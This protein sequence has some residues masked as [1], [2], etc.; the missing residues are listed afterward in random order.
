[1]WRDSKDSLVACDDGKVEK[2]GWRSSKTVIACIL[3]GIEAG[4]PKRAALAPATVDGLD[5]TSVVSGL[6][7]SLGAAGSP[8]LL[9]SLTTAGFNVV[10]PLGVARLVDSP[11]IVVYTYKPSLDRLVSALQ[12]AQLPFS[13]ARIRLLS[14]VERVFEA[15]T[16]KGRLYLL[17]WGLDREE[18]VE[19]VESA[20]IHARK[21]EPLRIA[22]YT[23]SEASEA[24][25]AA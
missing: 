9:D 7:L 1:M 14:L 25:P 3:W 21:P 11:T 15:E 16:R 13:E 4:L 23:A 22:H 6:M 5:A 2:L 8:L 18:A 24:L 19:L 10:S 17:A 20:Q 12:S